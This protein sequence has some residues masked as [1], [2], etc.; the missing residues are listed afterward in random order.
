[1]WRPKK[2]R[3]REG[4]EEEKRKKKKKRKRKKKKRKRKKG[5]NI[6]AIA[7][8][9]SHFLHTKYCSKCSKP[10]LPSNPVRFMAPLCGRRCI[11]SFLLDHICNGHWYP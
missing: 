10:I 7:K 4:E 2:K 5:R 1:M 11:C 8:N 6:S 3:K 9:T